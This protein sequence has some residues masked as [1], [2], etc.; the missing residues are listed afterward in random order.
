MVTNK[1]VNHRENVM[2]AIRKL[3]TRSTHYEDDENNAVLWL[4]TGFRSVCVDF[5]RYD[6]PANSIYFIFPGTRVELSFGEH[7]VGWIVKFSRDV[8]K[9]NIRDEMNIKN[10]DLMA[11]RDLAMKMVLSPK[12]GDRIHT[13]IE[14]IDE[15]SGSV[16]PNKESAIDSLLK[17]MLVYCDSSCNIRLQTDNHKHQVQMVTTFKH[18][19]SRH[20]T[21][22]HHVSDYA[23][24]M[25]IS[26]KYLNQVVKEVLGVTA[27]DV[28]HEQLIIQARRELKFSSQSIKEIAFDLGF[29]EPFHFSNYFKKHVGCSPTEYR[30]Q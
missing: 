18:L 25:N 21:R 23:G 20:F 22:V 4:R 5:K 15:L 24:M 7:P 17:T 6:T 10:A 13:I 2:I 11:S 30:L 28:I 14:M 16:I 1:R 29:S 3:D 12:I 26:P 27:K 9:Q 8:L 19:V